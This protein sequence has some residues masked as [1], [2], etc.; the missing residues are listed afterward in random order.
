MVVVSGRT[1]WHY[2]RIIWNRLDQIRTCIPKTL[3]VTTGQR[4]GVDA[5]AAAS[6]SGT[7][8]AA[9]YTLS[10]YVWLGMVHGY[11]DRANLIAT[12]GQVLASSPLRPDFLEHANA[13]SLVG[14]VSAK[15][16]W[17]LAT[18]Q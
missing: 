13:N 6:T 12:A 15:T 5:S 14:A 10:L 2:W 16:A 7:I 4:H 18:G 9:S 8:A 1:D 11:G 17:P 3:L